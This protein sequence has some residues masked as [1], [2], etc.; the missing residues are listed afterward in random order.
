MEDKKNVIEDAVST[1]EETCPDMPDAPQPVSAAATA[2]KGKK[3]K[4][5]KQELLDWLIH[6]A[7]ALV[8][9]V[10]IRSFFFQII[11]VDGDSMNDTLVHN[12]RLFVTVLDVKLSGADRGDI[13]ICKYPG[14][15]NTNFVKRI[16]AA[17]GDQVYRENGITH[18]IYTGED[19]ETV[20]ETL[21]GEKY[22]IYHVT[23]APQ[24]YGPYT[25][26]EDEYFAVGDNRYNSH[27]SR[28]WMDAA[29]DNDVGPI[30]G[31]ML[32]GRV[33]TVIWPLSAIRSPK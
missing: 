21:D 6:I 4:T 23:E 29:G 1:A 16:V 9:V 26:G 15:G 10:I 11:R 7:I 22:T 28:N 17:P 27:D 19:G 5:W 8:L 33:R 14:R 25:L 18:V 24:D 13:V 2:G 30:T 20:D 31:D 12:E 32:V 3:K